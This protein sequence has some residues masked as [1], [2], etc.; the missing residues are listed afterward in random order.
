MGLSQ[1]QGGKLKKNHPVAGILFLKTGTDQAKPLEIEY[2]HVFSCGFTK[3]KFW[4]TCHK[5]CNSPKCIFIMF[6]RFKMLS[7][8]PSWS[9][10]HKNNQFK[11]NYI[12]FCSSFWKTTWKST[13][14]F[15]EVSCLIDSR[16]NYTKS[17][18]IMLY[19]Y[20]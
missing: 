19:L 9:A 11:Q 14:N 16:Q 5:L 8:T 2:L 12:I 7:F 3:W 20:L 17:F 10:L 18:C 4:A 1:I 6:L 13:W 15:I